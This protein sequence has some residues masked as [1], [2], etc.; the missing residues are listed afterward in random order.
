[1]LAGEVNRPGTYAKRTLNLLGELDRKDIETF[2]TLCSFAIYS[3]AAPVILYKSSQVAASYNP[4]LYLKHGLDLTTLQ[5]MAE[6]GLIEFDPRSEYTRPPGPVRYFGHTLKLKTET[7]LKVGN[8]LFT[9][10][11]WQIARLMTPREIPDFFEY[12]KRMWKTSIVDEA[13]EAAAKAA[14]GLK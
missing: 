13:A 14:P 11:G 1:V 9:R 8:A 6:I 3:L 2:T 12:V 4:G 10:A 5:E 7:P